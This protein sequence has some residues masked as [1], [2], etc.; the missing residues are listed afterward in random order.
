M[1]RR[2]TGT[3]FLLQ[4]LFSGGP[5]DVCGSSVWA[6]V[7]STSRFFDDQ[8]ESVHVC[9]SISGARQVSRY[10]EVPAKNMC[11]SIIAELFDLRTLR[12]M[13]TGLLWMDAVRKMLVW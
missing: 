12:L 8:S 9:D 11:R 1:L 7:S 10:I 5:V 2:D 13:E 4:S 6:H 3:V